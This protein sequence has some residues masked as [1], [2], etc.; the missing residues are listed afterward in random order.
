MKVRIA[1]ANKSIPIKWFKE[2]SEPGISAEKFKPV[3][4]LQF[5]YV[6]PLS[7]SCDFLCHS[8]Q[9]VYTGNQPRSSWAGFIQ[10]VSVGTHLHPADIA[11]LPIIDLKSS[12]ESSQRCLM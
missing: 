4:E 11:M 2:L 8:D 12:D 1:T 5:L 3:I 10:D 9:K 7:T 6:L